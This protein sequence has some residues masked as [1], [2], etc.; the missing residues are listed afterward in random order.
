M[1]EI[2]E[3]FPFVVFFVC[4]VPFL[5]FLFVGHLN[6]CILLRF[7]LHNENAAI[8]VENFIASLFKPLVAL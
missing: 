8:C 3:M 6:T 1:S 2:F 7:D 4:L 5:C